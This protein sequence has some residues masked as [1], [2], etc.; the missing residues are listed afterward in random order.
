MSDENPY[1]TAPSPEPEQPPQPSSATDT[2][3]SPPLGPTGASPG[4]PPQGP[5]FAS[6][7]Q[8][9]VE[10]SDYLVWS[11]ILTAGSF[12]CCVSLL[13]LPFGIVGIVFSAR[14]NNKKTVGN[15][16]DAISDS[17]LAKKMCIIGTIVFGVS[18]LATIALWTLA[19][20]GSTL[21]GS[22]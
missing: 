20:V 19:I 17:S 6:G 21:G 10:V 2:P 18:V 8:P 7:A 13:A 15:Y 14:A 3:Q 1:G 9:P 5:Q 22:N 16:T 12:F 11:I 4:A